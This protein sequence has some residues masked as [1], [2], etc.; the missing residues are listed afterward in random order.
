M[1]Q[2]DICNWNIS[3][4]L[5]SLNRQYQNNLII[6][7]ANIRKINGKIY[8]HSIPN[9]IMVTEKQTANAIEE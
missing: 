9:D 6:W 2:Q 8:E 3:V 7:L 4:P 1:Q 5:R